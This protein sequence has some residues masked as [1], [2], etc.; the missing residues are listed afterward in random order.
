MANIS[1][2]IAYKL[3]SRWQV[4]AN[5]GATSNYGFNDALV[6]LGVGLL[7]EISQDMKAEIGWKHGSSA[8][9]D[10]ISSLLRIAVIF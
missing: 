8:N 1:T 10:D 6:F 7:Y 9:K 5:I 3:G 2:A 4:M